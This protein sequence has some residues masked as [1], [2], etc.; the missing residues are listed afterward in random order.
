MQRRDV[1]LTRPC[2]MLETIASRCVADTH[3]CNAHIHNVWERGCGH[4]CGLCVVYVSTH[5]YVLLVIEQ[6]VLESTT[7]GDTKLQN[8]QD[9]M[10]ALDKSLSSQLG[11]H[12]FLPFARQHLWNVTSTEICIAG[13]LP[14][15]HS[16]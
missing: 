8:L 3:N 4:K 13:I 15:K 9:S 5:A 2:H 6:Q 12:V 10:A 1:H 7:K 16:T 11:M 14:L